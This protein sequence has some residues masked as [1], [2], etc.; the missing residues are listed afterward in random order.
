MKKIYFLLIA[1]ILFAFQSCTV[2]KRRYMEGYHV[3]WNHR[4]GKVQKA[5]P[6]EV[7]LDEKKELS[8]TQESEL[9][10]TEQIIVESE[11]AHIE[12]AD[13]KN[14]SEAKL[15]NNRVA[16]EK[17]NLKSKKANKSQHIEEKSS[18][19]TS[20][21]L[22]PT[23]T[24]QLNA[25]HTSSDTDLLLLVILCL[26]LPPLAVYLS[27]GSWNTIC[28]ISLILTLFFW[29]PGVIFALIVVL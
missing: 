19:A 24:A 12:K 26:L 20:H 27:E 15:S 4:S 18:M 9:A 21:R 5:D 14:S 8:T 17:S 22:L 3:E 23:N 13:A 6:I 1:A 7:A 11:V 29:I 16:K 10:V 28:W 2:E 25:E